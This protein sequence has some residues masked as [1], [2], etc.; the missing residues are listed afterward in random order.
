MPNDC[1]NYLTIVSHDN[2]KQLNRMIDT[3]FLGDQVSP[4]PKIEIRGDRGIKLE[5]YSRWEPNF[6]WLEGLVKK[7]PDCWIK[8]EWSEEGGGAGVWVGGRK[9]KDEK[10]EISSFMWDDICIEGLSA[11]FSTAK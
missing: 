1:W 2:P 11:Y 4:L 7:Y 8:N 10:S 6:N 9:F 3:E 5:V